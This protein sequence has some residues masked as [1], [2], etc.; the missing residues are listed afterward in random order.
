MLN[1]LKIVF[2]SGIKI[3]NLFKFKD[4]IHSHIRSLVVYKFS[5]SGCN[6]TYIGKTKRHHKVRMCE[7]LGTSF[8]TGEPTKFNEK[9]ST[10]IRD[11]IRDS[12]HKND[13]ESFKLLSFGKNN[14]E[15]LIKE[16]LLLQKFSPTLINK[17]VKN[18]KLSLF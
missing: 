13:F 14:F 17:Q 18:F 5:C 3:G 2:K 12:G 15:C 16:K 4:S 11:H 6:A 9:S 10:A 1:K 7:H 8:R